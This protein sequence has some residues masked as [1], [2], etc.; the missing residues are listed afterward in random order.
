MIKHKPVLIEKLIELLKITKNGIY[1][2]CTLGRGGHSEAILKKLT[3]GQ[4]YC[5]E[6]DQQAIQESQVRLKKYHNYEIIPTNFKFLKMVLQL[7]NISEVDGI[8]YDLGVSSPQ[9]DEPERGFSYQQDGPLDMRMDQR[10]TLDAMQI[11][12]EWDFE[13]LVEILYLYGEERFAKFIAKKII[14]VREIKKITTTF[15]LVAVIKSAL[16]MKILK[17][18]KHPA[19]KTFQ[20]LRIAVND[21][22]N[23]LMVSLKQA[24]TLLKPQGTLIVISFHSLEDRIVKNVFKDLVFAKT[25]PLVARL[26]IISDFKTEYELLTKKPILPTDWE[27]ATNRRARSAKLRAIRKF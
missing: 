25:N 13:K 5:L 7:R 11:V 15:E 26:P 20:A 27:I 14:K 4:L 22:L 24:I 19:K 1:V 10:Q 17:Q 2:D 12:N 16:P 8:I 9:L 21:E 6:Q 23:S 18:Q 3:T